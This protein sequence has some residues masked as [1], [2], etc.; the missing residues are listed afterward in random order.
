MHYLGC[1]CVS[2]RRDLYNLAQKKYVN[3]DTFYFNYELRLFIRT[4]QI[5]IF[6]AND[7]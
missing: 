5:Y 1:N 4:R 6:F 2:L 3:R 7:Y